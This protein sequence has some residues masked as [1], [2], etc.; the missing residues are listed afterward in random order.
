[1]TERART[2]PFVAGA[3]EGECEP[4]SVWPAAEA[5]PTSATL[6]CPPPPMLLKLP[7]TYTAEPDSVRHTASAE[8]LPFE[9]GF[10]SASRTGVTPEASNAATRPRLA[11]AIVVKPPPTYSSVPSRASALTRLF[12]SGVHAEAAPSTAPNCARFVCGWPPAS[13][14]KPPTNTLSLA[15][16]PV[17]ATALTE[18]TVPS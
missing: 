15:P 7:P 13:L 2:D 4:S 17:A 8:T 6:A 14:K 18:A 1:M 5:V 12:G 16:S 10:Q 11:P 9:F 3:H